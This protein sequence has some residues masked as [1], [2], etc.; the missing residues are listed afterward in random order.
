MLDFYAKLDIMT[1]SQHKQQKRRN[2]VSIQAQLNKA[3]FQQLCK[4]YEVMQTA[5]G[6]VLGSME[7]IALRELSNCRPC[8]DNMTQVQ[9]HMLDEK[10]IAI[11]TYREYI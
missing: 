7:Q 2:K 5:Q 8:L 6:A 4:T 11:Y 9:K 3:A 1:E 10:V